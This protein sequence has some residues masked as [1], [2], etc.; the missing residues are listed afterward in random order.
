MPEPRH[1]HLLPLARRPLHELA[2][3]L[4]RAHHERRVGLVVDRVPP[5]REAR[6]ALREPQLLHR[7]LAVRE[8]LDRQRVEVAQLGLDVDRAVDRGRV[9]VVR[10]ELLDVG[11]RARERVRVVRLGVRGGVQEREERVEPPEWVGVDHVEQRRLELV[12]LRVSRSALFRLRRAEGPA[13]LERFVRVIV[14]VLEWVVFWMLGGRYSAHE[15]ASERRVWAY[16]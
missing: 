7:R 10:R 13:H 1:A 12:V 8:R 15:D 3:A 5:V 6:L 9:R 16:R 4:D 14:A 2:H 11:D